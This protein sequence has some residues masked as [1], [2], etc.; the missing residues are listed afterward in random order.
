[1][2]TFNIVEVVLVA[3]VIIVLGLSTA[4]LYGRYKNKRMT[5]IFQELYEGL[6]FLVEIL[7]FAK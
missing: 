1:M 7:I 2:V 5:E 4:F 3:M 6:R